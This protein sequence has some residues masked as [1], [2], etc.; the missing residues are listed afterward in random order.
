MGKRRLAV[1]LA[2][3]FYTGYAP[4]APGT[5]GAL[6][7]WGPAWV[8]AAEFGLPAWVFAVAAIGIGPLGVWSAGVASSVFKSHDPSKVVIDEVIGQWIA[9]APASA[10]SWVQWVAALVL[11]RLFD[12]AKPFGIRRLEGLPAGVGVVADDVGAGLCAMLGVGLIRWIGL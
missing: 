9:L 4:V 6:C 3:W 11:F 7:A 8:L 1:I 12:I 5:V 2:T 10:D